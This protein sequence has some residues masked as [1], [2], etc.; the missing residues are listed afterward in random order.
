MP[1]MIL[2]PSKYW[3]GYGEFQKYVYKMKLIVTWI[4]IISMAAIGMAVQWLPDDRKMVIFH[5]LGF[6]LL[7]ICLIVTPIWLSC[8]A[9]IVKKA[10]GRAKSNDW[11]SVRIFL[12][13]RGWLI[14]PSPRYSSIVRLMLHLCT[15][16]KESPKQE[17]GKYGEYLKYDSGIYMVSHD[18]W[19]K[20]TDTINAGWIN[21]EFFEKPKYLEIL[22]RAAM[23]IAILRGI[24]LFND[25]LFRNH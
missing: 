17:V 18:G 6:M 19:N 1:S 15:K 13:S 12:I 2:H 20:M 14:Y 22:L 4:A 23:V 3:L 25:M 7:A 16:P 10:I 21:G 24:F 8:S 5:V 11:N 9:W